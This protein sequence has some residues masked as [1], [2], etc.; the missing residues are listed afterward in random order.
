MLLSKYSSDRKNSLSSM[1][2]THYTP[3][4]FVTAY[5]CLRNTLGVLG[6]RLCTWFSV[7]LLRKV[8]IS[9]FM[10]SKN[11]IS[12]TVSVRFVYYREYLHFVP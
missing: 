6:S 12:Y 10:Y 8:A 1:F 2:G 9:K 7:Q 5:Y 4:F 11:L 3:D